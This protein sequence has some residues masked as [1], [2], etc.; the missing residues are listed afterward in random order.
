MIRPQRADAW[1]VRIRRG[2]KYNI[3]P[4]TREGW[5]VTVAY[6]LAT[7]ALTPVILTPTPI[8]VAVWL[9]LF[10]AATALFLVIAWRTSS[11][12][13]DDSEKGNR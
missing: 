2:A 13:A 1:F 8:H 7:L 4:C 9:I 10:L 6:V 11:P 12:A 3:T 5:A